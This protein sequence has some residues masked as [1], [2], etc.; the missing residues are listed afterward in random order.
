M[1][2]GLVAVVV[3]VPFLCQCNAC[4]E[5]G[6]VQAQI[7]DA[8]NKGAYAATK[9]I[10]GPFAGPPPVEA[11]SS[12]DPDCNKANLDGP[13]MDYASA[14]LSSHPG[15]ACTGSVAGYGDCVACATAHCC[16]ESVA[17]FSEGTCTC[18]M[19][20][21]TPGVSW[22]ESVPCG[23]QDDFYTAE[24]ACLVDHCAK[25]CPSK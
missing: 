7:K 23:E 11:G 12:D 18:L 6:S 22:P 2:S 24:N 4:P 19:A 25:E 14:G 15:G 20:L 8:A 1:K 13:D 16:A 10:M 9:A 21:R 3:L 5:P 17:C